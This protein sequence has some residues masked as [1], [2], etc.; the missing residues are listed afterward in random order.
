MELVNNLYKSHNLI[1]RVL[2][3]ICIQSDVLAYVMGVHSGH[4]PKL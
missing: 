3:G 1:M 4:S 2:S